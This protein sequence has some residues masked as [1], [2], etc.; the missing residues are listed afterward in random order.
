MKRIQD[1]INVKI[2]MSQTFVKNN[3]FCLSFKIVSNKNF[4]KFKI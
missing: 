4:K 2:E 1:K 3:Y